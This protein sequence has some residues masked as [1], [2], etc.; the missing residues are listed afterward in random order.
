MNAPPNPSQHPKAVPAPMPDSEASRIKTL[1][2]YRV[3]DTEPE[4]A[5]DDVVAIAAQ[6][7]ETS[8]ALVSLVDTSRQWFKAAVGID[9]T[10]TPRDVAFCA[11][12]ILHS[13]VMVI[14]DALDDERFANNPL[15]VSGPLIRFY[16]G[17]PLITAKG[18]ALGTLCV[19]DTKPR[20]LGDAQICA[21]EALARQVV[22]Q[23]EM[24][25]LL[26]R[27]NR[28]VEARQR[29]E[30][31]LQAANECLEQRVQERTQVLSKSN[32][33]LE[34]TLQALQQAQAQLVHSEKMKALGQMV[35]GIAHEI[36]NPINFIH[37]NLSHLTNYIDSLVDFLSLYECAFPKL[38]SEIQERATTLDIDFIKQDAQKIL[39]SMGVGT[40]RV[41]EIVL[42][43][44]NFSRKDE[45]A[46]KAVD[47][48]EG[49]ESTLMMLG[50][51]LKAS[52]KRPTIE[53]VRDFEPLSKIECYAGQLNQV[54]MNILSN[55]IDAID[56]KAKQGKYT[57]QTP[58]II[59][60]T[61]QRADSVLIY[62]T[63]N[64]LGMPPAVR[65]RIFEPFFT[66]K[67]VG[68]GTGMGMAISHQLITEKHGGKLECFS[69]EGVGTQFCIE[70]PTRIEASAE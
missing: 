34:E 29:A 2:S 28:E 25:L 23:L 70:I 50:H 5:Y 31:T 19:I 36:N 47:I 59:L 18:Y 63:D 69:S 68:Q 12:A 11:H 33:Q 30:A 54:F 13:Q 67:V 66:T 58:Q 14:P 1:L 37:A 24:R 15:V 35:A 64:A 49:L 20:Q 43:L 61:E 9:A 48:Y 45:A 6:I 53:I 21:L 40:G 56:G 3:L 4:A 26:A 32:Q 46:Y 60:R 8:V 52:T 62:I 7:C 42:S 38:T 55:A 57:A 22:S 10:E 27:A 39:S 16:A 41:Q 51:R 65:E 17:A 44:R